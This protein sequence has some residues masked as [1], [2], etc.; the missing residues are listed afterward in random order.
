MP[1]MSIYTCTQESFDSQ[2]LQL[3]KL[4]NIEHVQITLSDEERTVET[5]KHTRFTNPGFPGVGRKAAE[6]KRK[7]GL[8]TGLTPEAAKRM[9]ATKRK[10]YGSN[11]YHMQNLES[12]TKAKNKCQEL[13]NRP[14]VEQLRQLANQHQLKLGSGWV[15]K[16]DHW[17]LEQI[18]LIKDRIVAP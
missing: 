12:R 7:L 2:N 18:D 1:A 3:S 17:I 8:P 16:P 6:T 11:T 15:R 4:F 14:I 13:E 9:V 5:V 10:R